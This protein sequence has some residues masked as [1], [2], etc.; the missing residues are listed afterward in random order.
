MAA[1]AVPQGEDA[2]AAVAVV[3]PV[4]EAAVAVAAAVEAGATADKGNKTIH[5]A[6]PPRPIHNALILTT[7]ALLIGLEVA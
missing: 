4:E 2:E 7:I 6:L 3:L 1:A 5:A